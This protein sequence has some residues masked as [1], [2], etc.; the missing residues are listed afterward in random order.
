VVLEF[1][2]TWCAPCIGEI[3]VLNALNASVDPAKVQI[4]SVDDEDP[5]VV[6]A[7]LRK[8]PISGWIGL[9]T[10]SKVFERFN[11][12]AR[13][14]TVVVGPDGR[15]ASTSMRPEALNA[16]NLLALAN[17]APLKPAEPNA[18]MQA[19][20]SKATAQAFSEQVKLPGGSSEALFQISLT[21]GEAAANGKEPDTHVMMLG[22]GLLD[23]TNATADIVLSY[24][25]GIPAT[26]ITDA[27][28]VSKAIYSLHVKAPDAAPGQ[29]V[30]AI[31]LAVASGAHLHIE[32]NKTMK[33]AYVLTAT[34][35]AAGHLAHEAQGGAAF[36][37]RKRETLQCLNATLGQLAGAI[38][39][40]LEMPVVDETNLDGVVM[41]TLKIAPKDVASANAALS[42]LGLKL[43]QSKRPIETVTVSAAPAPATAPHSVN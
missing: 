39:A 23:I 9:D 6:Q 11:V 34:P 19:E 7:F 36:Y 37:S 38:E 5:A 13:P 8:K 29:L 15:V 22:P 40:A 21:P 4:I 25:T 32:H 43:T 35:E 28:G 24:G 2:A 14:V 10:S 27:A 12:N 33:D 16:A 26:R 1:W 17:G 31:E 3:P 30:P 18:A 20:A 41:G 42:T